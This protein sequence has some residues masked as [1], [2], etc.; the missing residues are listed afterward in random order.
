VK[1]PEKER[2]IPNICPANADNID[3]KNIILA[4]FLSYFKSNTI[5]YF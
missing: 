4:N 1:N 2:I 5:L 3:A